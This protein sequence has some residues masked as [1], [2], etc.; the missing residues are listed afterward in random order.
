MHL[1][2]GRAAARLHALP[3]ADRRATVG[4]A[5]GRLFGPAAVEPR[6]W[7]EIT[8]AEG[9]NSRGGYGSCMPSGVLTSVGPA[10]RAPI[11]GVHW[12]GSDVP[13]RWTGFIEGAVLSGHAAARGGAV[14]RVSY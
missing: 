7:A 4:A 6:H 2:P 9:P 12:A 1:V 3:L 5:L 13:T 8:W 11:G 14:L 10:L